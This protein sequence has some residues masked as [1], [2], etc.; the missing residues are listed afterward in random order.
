MTMAES[1]ESTNA[2]PLLSHDTRPFTS[3]DEAASSRTPAVVKMVFISCYSLVFPKV[4][5]FQVRVDTK[6]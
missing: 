6:E 1:D 5:N 3:A 4:F 2:L